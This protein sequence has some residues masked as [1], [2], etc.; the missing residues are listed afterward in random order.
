LARAGEEEAGGF[1]SVTSEGVTNGL[2]EILLKGRIVIGETDEE[3]IPKLR[4]GLWIVIERDE[5]GEIVVGL[6]RREFAGREIEGAVEEIDEVGVGVEGGMRHS[7][8]REER[9]K[10]EESSK[11]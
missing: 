1:G 4:C 9:G 7:D 8:A 5:L 2:L 10:T 11:V 3:R 6:V